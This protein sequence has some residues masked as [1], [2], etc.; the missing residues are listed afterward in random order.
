MACHTTASPCA[1]CTAPLYFDTVV[2]A[3]GGLACPH[4]R[5]L[6]SLL[7]TP[8]AL[9][10]WQVTAGEAARRWAA[11]QLRPDAALLVGRVATETSELLRVELL[12]C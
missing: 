8:A 5:Q 7:S 10:R 4:H 2:N 3:P 6:G 11:L 12:R 9:T 1:G